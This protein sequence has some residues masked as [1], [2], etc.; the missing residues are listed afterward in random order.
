MLTGPTSLHS[1]A[2]TTVFELGLQ[3][4][5]NER[6]Y[7]IIDTQMVWSKGPVN[8]PVPPGY[9]ERAYDIYTYIG[10]HL[11]K[12][13]D[14]QFRAEWYKDV[15]GLGYAGGFGVP[16][17]DYYEFTFG[18]DYHPCKWIQIRPEIRYDYASHDNFGQ[19]FDKKNQLSIA[20][21]CLFK[22]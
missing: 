21:E 22:F 4:N 11:D 13:I 10:Y 18:P 19:N 8:A 2:N 14:L 17:T 1:G 6:W 5:W 15:D 12:C 20:A 3:Q 9:L 7:Q 16:H